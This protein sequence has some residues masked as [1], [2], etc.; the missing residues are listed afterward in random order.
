LKAVLIEK[1]MTELIL[2]RGLPGSGKS[3]LARDIMGSR[4]PGSVAWLEADQYFYDKAGNYNWDGMHIWDA[5]SWCQDETN[6]V[7]GEGKTVIVSNT[8]TMKRELR[9]Y[10]EM[11][12]EYGKNP[13]VICMQSNWGSIHGV[14]EA[15]MLNMKKRFCF[16]I[17]DMFL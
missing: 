1:K 4:E 12:Q 8:F 7:L 3:T 10:F 11:I 5:H 6:K 17:S 2:I 15:V 14:P 13:T 16:D 9:P